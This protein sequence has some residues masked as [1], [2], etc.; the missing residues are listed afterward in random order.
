MNDAEAYDYI[1]AYLDDIT[2]RMIAQRAWNTRHPDALDAEF[3]ADED[4]YYDDPSTWAAGRS[5]FDPNDPIPNTADVLTVERFISL[6]VVAVTA[7]EKAV[8]GE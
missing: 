3:A 5:T 7:Y 8:R 4:A 1:R 6:V 2:A